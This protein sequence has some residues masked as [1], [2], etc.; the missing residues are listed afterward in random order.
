MTDKVDMRGIINE[1]LRQGRIDGFIPLDELQRICKEYSL[2]T[3]KFEEVK[4]K[5]QAA[6]ID[7]VESHENDEYEQDDT[8]A[9]KSS[10]PKEENA[11]EADSLRAYFHQIAKIPLLTHEQVCELSLKMRD[12]DRRARDKLVESNLRLVVSIAKHYRTFGLPYLDLIQ[13]GNMGL[14]RAVEKFDPNRG[15]RFSTYATWWIKFTIRRA[16]AD[17][18]RMIR[19]PNYII[20]NISKISRIR[21]QF[22]QDNGREPSLKELSVLS[23]MPEAKV[24]EVLSIIQE[25]LALETVVD[26]ERQTT[27]MDFVADD[28]PS[29]NPSDSYFDTVRMRKFEELLTLLNEREAIIIR[30][31]YGFDTG[32]KATLETVG[33]VL[34]ITRERVRQLEAKAILKLRRSDLFQEVSNLFKQ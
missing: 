7:L 13:E 8:D 3:E 26:S 24:K 33:N 34:G 10:P 32:E 31:R 18:G 20:A 14:I 4:L 16:L 25:P 21:A 28:S 29:S 22:F 30:M 17:Q 23:H 9:A 2:S 5:I 1:L 6:N 15:L 19:I 27:I 11:Y 12:G